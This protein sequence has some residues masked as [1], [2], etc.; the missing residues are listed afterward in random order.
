MGKRLYADA[1]QHAQAALE[2]ARS[3]AVDP[4]SS[5]WIGEAL[6]LRARAEAALGR[7]DASATA[8]EA[9]RHLVENLN[10]SH[11]LIAEARAMAAGHER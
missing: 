6:V 9:L 1:V 10:S 11:P 2:L 4:K 3:S 5:A 8:Q 7:K